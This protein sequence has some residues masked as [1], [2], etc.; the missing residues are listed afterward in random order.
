VIPPL[1]DRPEDVP[2]LAEHFLQVFRAKHRRSIESIHP[3]AVHALLQYSWP[4]NV[5]ELEHIIERAVIVAEGSQL[6]A[7]DLSP[8]VKASDRQSAKSASTFTIPPHHTLA[9]L[10]K[11]AILQT[12]ERTRGNKRKAARILGVYRP[13][14]YSKLRKHH[15]GEVA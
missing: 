10:E 14:L 9:E 12:L 15:L 5:R 3:D 1:R 7:D 2:L 11:L 8:A 4:G 6:M 13:T